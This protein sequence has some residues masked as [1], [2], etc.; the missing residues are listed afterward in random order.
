MLICKTSK[1]S[2]VLSQDS[3]LHTDLLCYPHLLLPVLSPCLFSQL[4]PQIPSLSCLNLYFPCFFYSIPPCLSPAPCFPWLWALFTTL[5]AVRGYATST[6]SGVSGMMLANHL[7]VCFL[8]SRHIPS[9]SMLFLLE[10]CGPAP[11][12]AQARLAV[13]TKRSPARALI[14]QPCIYSHICTC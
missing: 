10:S 4:S 5:F 6:S 13:R 1:F 8:R 7:L 2:C 3:Y 11:L 14:C 9:F 12:P